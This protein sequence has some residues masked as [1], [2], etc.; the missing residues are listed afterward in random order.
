MAT[1]ASSVALQQFFR[2]HTYSRQA[3]RR[4]VP[5]SSV[6][7]PTCRSQPPSITPLRR[8]YVRVQ[9][10]RLKANFRAIF[11][12]EDS[13]T[14]QAQFRNTSCGVTFFRSVSMAEHS[15]VRHFCGQFGCRLRRKETLCETKPPNS[16][17]FTGSSGY[18]TVSQQR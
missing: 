13:R 12:L 18:E 7:L 11:Y 16:M 1:L 14:P 8:K 5:T 3:L 15:Q 9:P 2:R 6:D 10:S 4:R 17:I